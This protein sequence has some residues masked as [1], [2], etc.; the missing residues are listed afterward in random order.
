[1]ERPRYG[2]GVVSVE[3]ARLNANEVQLMRIRLLVLLPL[4]FLAPVVTAEAAPLAVGDIVTITD[5]PGTT[6]G[7]EFNMF[8]NGSAQS[9]ITFC[10]QR[11]QYIGFNQQFKVGGVTTYADD[12]AGNDYISLQTQWLYSNMRAGTLSGYAHTNAMADLLQ[13]AIWYFENEITLSNPNSNNF[14]KMA[15]MA[16]TNGFKGAS[17]VKVLNL[18]Y[19]NGAKAQDQLALQVPGPAAL[20]LVVPG[21]AALAFMRRRRTF[22]QA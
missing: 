13:T 18:F 5:G 10:L 9:F 12:A 16:V 3:G 4:L 1:M 8:V 14:I 7:G 19:M 22:P 11:T 17:N 2:A 15:N 21:L 20:T 6:G